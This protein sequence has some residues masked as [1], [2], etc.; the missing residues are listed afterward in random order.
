MKI[1]FGAFPK[2]VVGQKAISVLQQ[3]KRQRFPTINLLPSADYDDVVVLFITSKKQFRK[4]KAFCCSS[5][6]NHIFLSQDSLPTP[7][8]IVCDPMADE[9]ADD[10]AK[11]VI[12]IA[13]KY[14]YWIE[15]YLENEDHKESV[16]PWGNP[17]SG[18]DK[19]QLFA[20]WLQRVREHLGPSHKKRVMKAQESLKRK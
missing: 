16:P 6:N 19:K 12:E 10:F 11:S 13:K 9:K 14:S 8:V 15:N 3:L 4:G 17:P 2:D 1:V 7:F 20:A 18:D 5:H